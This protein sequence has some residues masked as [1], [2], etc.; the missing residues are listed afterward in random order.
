MVFRPT[1]YGPTEY[2]N[3]QP[4]PSPRINNN[5]IAYVG[6][7]RK[8]EPK[9]NSG[10][11]ERI[12]KIDEEILCYNADPG[13][14]L[15]RIKENDRQFDK[16]IKMPFTKGATERETGRTILII[17]DLAHHGE[18]MQGQFDISDAPYT[19]EGKAF[20]NTIR[21]VNIGNLK[22]G[23]IGLDYRLNA[24]TNQGIATAPKDVKFLAETLLKYGYDS[25]KRLYL[26]EPPHI[27]ESDEGKKFRTVKKL[28]TLVEWSKANF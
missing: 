3:H 5:I 15:V 6:S 21:W 9:R 13:F 11:V 26:L 19:Y 14:V 12:P 27:K 17:G 8:N 16:F 24:K 20:G 18:A 28:E 10:Q 25:K 1:S 7:S 22:Q 4:K 23:F 2:Q